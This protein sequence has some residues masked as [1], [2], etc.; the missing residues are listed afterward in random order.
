MV[1]VMVKDYTWL[2]GEKILVSEEGDVELLYIRKKNYEN[3][4]DKLQRPA[5]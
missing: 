5:R 4:K 1:L 3:N 2:P